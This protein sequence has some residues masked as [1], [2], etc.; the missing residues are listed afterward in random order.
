MKIIGV[1]HAGCRFFSSFEELQNSS[2]LREFTDI[3]VGNDVDVL[4]PY[5]DFQAYARSRE[6]ERLDGLDELDELDDSDV[7]LGSIH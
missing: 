4:R 5:A 3:I 2:L 1:G 7:K 6:Q